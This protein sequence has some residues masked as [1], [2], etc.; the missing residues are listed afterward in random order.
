MNSL[1]RREVLRLSAGVRLAVGTPGRP[2]QQAARDFTGVVA[3]SRP[4]AC[5][6]VYTRRGYRLPIATVAS[7]NKL[8]VEAIWMRNYL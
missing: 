1:S 5:C 7:P 6:G 3:E 2:G 4:P 8:D